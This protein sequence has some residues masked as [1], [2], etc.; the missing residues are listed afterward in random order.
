MVDNDTSLRVHSLDLADILRGLDMIDSSLEDENLH[1]NVINRE[2]QR[3]I[4]LIS[5]IALDV[6][7]RNII[8]H[9]EHMKRLRR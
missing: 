7:V 4:H 1:Q 3:R 9:R 8:R 5:H 2:T 6:G